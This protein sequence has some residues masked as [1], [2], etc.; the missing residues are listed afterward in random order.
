MRSTAGSVLMVFLG[1]G[2]GTRQDT[3]GALDP[4]G[5]GA[6]PMAY[7]GASGMALGGAGIGGAGRAVPPRGMRVACAPM[8]EHVAVMRLVRRS[9]PRNT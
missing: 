6:A 3:S 2:C 7:G 1:F 9:S 8:R 4:V 5:A